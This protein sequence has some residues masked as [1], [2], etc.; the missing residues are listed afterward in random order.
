LGQE[1]AQ[2]PQSL[3]PNSLTST[4]TPVAFPLPGCFACRGHHI[5]PYHRDRL[6]A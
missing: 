1:F 3:R 6:L 5:R 4:L 2:Q